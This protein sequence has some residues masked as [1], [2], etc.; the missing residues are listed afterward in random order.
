M[1]SEFFVLQPVMKGGMLLA[2]LSRP[3][4]DQS[5]TTGVRFSTAPSSPVIAKI[6][7]GFEEADARPFSSVP[8]ILSA[9]LAQT[10]LDVGVGNLDL[11]DAVLQTTEGK[12][13]FGFKAFNLIGLVTLD[14]VHDRGPGTRMFRLF[15]A[16]STIV[17]HRSVQTAIEA[18]GFATHLK[19]IPPNQVS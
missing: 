18:A 11:Y 12:Q 10:L 17:V 7:Q 4:P 14:S 6:R 16:T 8:P 19:F 13:L 5:W 2:P 9:G 15:D 3:H 1:R